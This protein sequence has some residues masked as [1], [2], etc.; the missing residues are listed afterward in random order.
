MDLSAPLDPYA[1]LQVLPTAEDEVIRAAFR[2]LAFKFHPDRDV[3]E[4]A[5]LRMREINLAYALVKTPG[6][7]AAFDRRRRM[8][9]AVEAVENATQAPPT[10]VPSDAHSQR[11]TFG[12]YAGWTLSQVSRFDVDY[13]RWLSRHSSGIRFKTEIDTLLKARGVPA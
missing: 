13:L 11:L 12:R 3:T 5:A 9:N 4:Y 6:A 1:V 10:A 7:R 8:S 2:A